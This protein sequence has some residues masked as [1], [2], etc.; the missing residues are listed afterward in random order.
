[1][2]PRKP[3]GLRLRNTV[4][5]SAWRSRRELQNYNTAV[6]YRSSESTFAVVRT[7]PPHT[8]SIT[9]PLHADGA[10]ASNNTPEEPAD[11]LHGRAP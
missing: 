2:I 1:M 8:K 10:M 6:N 7:L 3:D 11:P 4:N 9:E 5:N